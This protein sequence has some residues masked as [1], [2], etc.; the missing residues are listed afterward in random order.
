MVTH[1]GVFE[2]IVVGRHGSE[3]AAY[4]MGMLEPHRV[5]GLVNDRCPGVVPHGRAVIIG[6]AEPGVAAGGIGG[7]VVGPGCAGHA[8]LGVA[9]VGVLCSRLGDLGESDVGH[10]R[11]HGQRRTDGILL[12][13]VERL[14]GDLRLAGAV[15]GAVV[16]GIRGKAEGERVDC[17]FDAAKHTVNV[18]VAG[19]TVGRY[20]RHG[21]LLHAIRSDWS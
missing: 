9:Q 5:A 13:G 20:C 12:T 10:R 16:G 3:G 17:P 19:G 11:V 2:G 8:R 4:L 18:R 1:D 14:K 21:L 7:R 6:V 15:V